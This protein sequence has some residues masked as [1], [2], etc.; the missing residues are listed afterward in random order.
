[1]LADKV[2]VERVIIPFSLDKDL[3]SSVKG[4]E[5]FTVD[6]VTTVIDGVL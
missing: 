4:E 5:E 3:A 2:H 1:M 6:I